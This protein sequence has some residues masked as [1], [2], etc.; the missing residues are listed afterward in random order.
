VKYAACVALLLLCPLAYAAEAYR[1]DAGVVAVGSVV[2]DWKDGGSTVPIKLYF[3][4]DL[5]QR[6]EPLPLIIF[7]HGLGGSR[8]GYAL[9]ATTWASHGYLVLLPTHVGSDT[10]IFLNVRGGDALARA[11]A[12]ANAQNAQRRC[13]DVSF[14][15]D[16]M[17]KA[18]AGALHDA[19]LPDLKGKVDLHHIGMSGHSFGAQTTLSIAGEFLG[20]RRDLADHRITAAIAMSPQPSR[21]PDQKKAFA[22]IHIP[23]FHITGTA[24]DS[25][26]GDTKARDR[27]IPFDNSSGPDTYLVIY[28]DATHMTFAPVSPDARLGQ[29]LRHQSDAG[30]RMSAIHAFVAE[31]TTAFWDA[32]LKNTPG[33]K[34]WL[35]TSFPRQL[36]AAGSFESK[37]SAKP[38]AGP[39]PPPH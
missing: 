23:V 13:R 14:C 20:L 34:A 6:T 3:P 17:E 37:S 12:A 39:P 5:A 16:Q 27:R 22:P 24:D 8:D 15:I 26:I 38:A 18:A 25:P 2:S 19:H 36:G 21:L 11:T 4:R 10:S 28:K 35:T 1:P 9:W 7:S 30:E 33:A 31:S 29:R 32:Y